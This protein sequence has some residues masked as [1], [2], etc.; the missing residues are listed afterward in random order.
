ME[1]ICPMCE[2]ET[3]VT[4]INTSEVFTIKNEEITI[5]VEYFKC[6]EC[7]E[8]FDDPKSLDD[9]INRAYREYRRVHGLIQPEEIREFR[10]RYGLTQKELSQLLGWGGATLSRYENGALQDDTHE[11]ILRL[12][13]DPK[14]LFRLIQDRPSALTQ[15]KRNELVEKFE[16][17]DS[18]Q[19]S[20]RSI[21]EERFSIHP[22]DLRNGFKK[23]DVTKLFNLIIYFCLN[24]VWKTKLNKLL[25]YADFKHFKDNS[26]SITGLR[27]KKFAYG[28][29]PEHY[30]HYFAS[31]HHE[32]KAIKV[33]EESSFNFTGEIFTSD[34]G[35]D[36]SIFSTA[37]I[38]TMEFVKDYFKDFN[39]SQI[40]NFSHEEKG[41]KET[42]LQEFIPYNHSDSLQI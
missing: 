40:R 42:N 16:L 5:P 37:E 3:K 19:C 2:K 26:S 8:A 36:L 32:E 21:Y 25:F 34:I 23:L 9:P 13:M 10:K 38:R 6:L 7:D 28:P 20:F 1:H 33:E 31:L 27:Y 11:T 22:P 29:V 4:K 14:N 18:V 15:Q 35:P 24:G 12:I 30:Y 41:Y 39:A 17:F